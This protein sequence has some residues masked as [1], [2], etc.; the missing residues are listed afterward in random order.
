MYPSAQAPGRPGPD[1][2][3]RIDFIKFFLSKILILTSLLAACQAAPPPAA[4]PTLPPTQLPSSPLP[5][6][7]TLLPTASPLP[8][9]PTLSASP[10][11][12]PTL[13][14][15]PT[16]PPAEFVW[17]IDGA[18]HPFNAPVG[19]A[20][21]PQ[22]NFYVMDTQ[23]AQV[24]KFDSQGNFL[25]MWGSPGV[26]QGQ[27]SFQVPDEGRLAVDSQGSLYVLD[28]SNFRLQKFD[29]Q[30]KFLAQWGSKGSGEGQFLEPSDIA[31]NA[32][33]Q[34]YVVDYQ[35]N[36][37]QKFDQNGKFLLRWGGNEQFSGIYSV[38]LDPGGNVLVSDE[39]GILRKFDSDGKFLSKIPAQKLGL[40][41]ISLWNIAVD[42]QGN[43][44]VADH[45][46]FRIVVLNPQGEV[47]ATWRGSE[48]GAASFSKLQD[49]AIDQAGAIYITDNQANLVQKFLPLK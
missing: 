31:I 27:F 41:S 8:P 40:Y 16:P 1:H 3:F 30:G 35:S 15:Q 34:V 20:L 33:D 29:S 21:D 32:Q 19:I 46:A 48:I 13:A 49:I 37:V 6:T 22:G 4:P 38:A 7:A 12:A 36:Y 17:K 10:T 26:G 24:K 47:L 2:L 45:D 14:S 28:D 18:P 25:L 43:I 5:A 39:R 9:S 44:Y 23:N 42:A 11:I